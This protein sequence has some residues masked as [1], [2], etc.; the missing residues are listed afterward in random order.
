MSLYL[1][2]ATT[3]LGVIIFSIMVVSVLMG[4]FYR[5]ILFNPLP[6]SD[7]LAVYCM[8]WIGY[9]GVGIALKYN[10]HPALEFIVDKLPTGAR[11]ML[12]I[13]VYLAILIFL[14]VVMFWGFRYAI[15]SG[16]FRMS[17]SLG[18]KMTIPLLSVP[19]G[20]LLGVIQLLIKFLNISLDIFD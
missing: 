5:Y 13:F 18:I 8:I 11:K 4:V 16:S 10:E 1:E 17:S 6:W 19:V 9:L 7:E 12:K 14:T 20:C 3:I 15:S 2:K